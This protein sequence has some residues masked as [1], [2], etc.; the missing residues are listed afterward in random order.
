MSNGLVLLDVDGVLANFV[1]AMIN[2][3][4]FP[5]TYDDVVKWNFQQD[6]GLSDA[7]FWAPTHSGDWWLNL[8]PYAHARGLLEAISANHQVVFA[9]SPSKDH[10]CPS[11]KVR[12]LELMQFLKPGSTDYVITKHK[13]LMAGSGAVLI[14]DSDANVAL[15]REAGGSAILFPRP[16]NENRRLSKRA[17]EFTLS[18]LRTMS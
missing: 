8:E 2:T 9:T 3:H 4:S 15:F 13:H 14:D 11:Q 6:F 10:R 7:E 12:W 17:A 5:I 1:Q 16:W 18:A